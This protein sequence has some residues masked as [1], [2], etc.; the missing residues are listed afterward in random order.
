MSVQPLRIL[1]ILPFY[2]GSLPVGNFCI[3]ALQK[4]GHDVSFFDAPQFYT[5]FQGLKKLHVASER[6]LQLEESFLHIISQAILAKAESFEPDMVLA[7]AQA[8][9]SRQLLRRFKKMA[10]PTAMWFV[11]DHKVF[12]YWRAFAPLFDVFAIIQKEPFISLLSEIGQKNSLYLPMAA[13]PDF[14][15]PQTLT[16]VEQKNFGADIGFMGA[17]YPNRRVAFRKFAYKNFKIWGTE[18]DGEVML[19]HHI[20]GQGMRISPEDTVKIYNATKVNINLHSSIQ[21]KEL[22]P[23]G[24]FVNPRTFELAAIGAFQVVDKRELMSELFPEDTLVTFSTPEEMLE[25]TEYYIAHPE[26]RHAF[27]NA[28]R[29][30]V[31][32]HH[33]YEHRMQSLLEYTQKVC[34]FPTR[35]QRE[36]V[37]NTLPDTLSDDMRTNIATLLESLHLPAHASFEEVT[38]RIQERQGTL[39]PTEVSVLFLDAWQKQYKK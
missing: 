23:M 20:Q 11:E 12:T 9:V 7:L 3:Q 38:K 29:A 21:S 25:K 22:V 26:E 4:L 24:D 31:L 18:W 39:S 13:L 33:T 1:V 32:A 27:S 5:A 34:T 8:P 16:P 37:Y 19:A 15:T 35:Q 2:G 14:H 28:A 36:S 30:H 10:I 17:G 6:L